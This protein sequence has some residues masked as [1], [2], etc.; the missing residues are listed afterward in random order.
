MTK[1]KVSII[2]P[3]YNAEKYIA[4]SIESVLAQT[5]QNWELLIV[6]D[7][8]TDGTQMLIDEYIR[9]DN[10][11]KFF[12]QQNGKQGKARN[13]AISNSIGE[14][15][16]FLDSDD[17]WLPEKL[18]IQLNQISH[19]NADL[20]FSESFVFYDDVLSFKETMG[21][22]K[23]YLKEKIGIESLIQGNCIPV[24][25]VLVKREKVLQVG[26]F[27]EDP[28]IA[29]AEDYHLWLKI[30]MSGGIL[31]GADDVL[32]LYRV[33]GSSSTNTDKYANKQLPF[34]Y[35]SL[36]KLF[37]EYKNQIKKKIKLIFNY[38]NRFKVKDKNELAESIKLNCK[39]LDIYYLTSLLLL[40]N[41]FFSIQRTK[42]YI[43]KFVNA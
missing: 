5:Y 27:I 12:Y 11:I 3:A 17:L 16:A 15:L 7:G 6:N 21:I 23:G 10:R 8:S 33:H 34:M 36:I 43:K 41:Y 1:P 40:F 28:L 14:Y 20:I 22:P 29:N 4:A 19:L 30:I 42:H 35:H 31:W 32:T 39:L 18:T 37:P 25:S 24:L 13:L 26:M 38:N 9:K 2:M